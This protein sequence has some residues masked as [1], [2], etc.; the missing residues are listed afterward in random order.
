MGVLGSCKFISVFSIRGE[1]GSV[2]KSGSRSSFL[3]WALAD[4]GGGGF[5]WV[6]DSFPVP[7]FSLFSFHCAYCPQGGQE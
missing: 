3:I 6:S 5:S 2:K 4:L 1:R 7:V